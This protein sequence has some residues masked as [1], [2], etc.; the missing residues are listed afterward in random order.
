MSHCSELA[1]IR[2]RPD[3]DSPNG[4]MIDVVAQTHA[5]AVP[6]A[7]GNGANQEVE[8][9]TLRAPER[10][11]RRELEIPRFATPACAQASVEISHDGR[12]RGDI[13]VRPCSRALV[14]TR[15]VTRSNRGR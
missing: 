9:P 10:G 12:A 2:L 4:T 5:L 6:S 7:T 8:R 13:S 14:S 15:I 11:A 3:W 1:M